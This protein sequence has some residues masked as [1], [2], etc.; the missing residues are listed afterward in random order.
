MALSPRLDSRLTLE[1]PVRTPDGGGGWT[2][3]WQAVG[4]LWGEI[5]ARSAR[6]GTVGTRPTARV[7]HRIT[8]RRGTTDAE[9]PRPDQRLRYRDRVFAIHGTGEADPGSAYLT[10]WAEEG[11]F[12]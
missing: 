9:R 4:T 8:I 2:V 6:E 7:T 11:P 12:S 10:V 3:A 5:D 1:A